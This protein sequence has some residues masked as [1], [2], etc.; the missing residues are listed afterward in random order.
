MTIH[1]LERPTINPPRSCIDGSHM[2]TVDRAEFVSL[3]AVHAC[4]H[5]TSKDQQLV[6]RRERDAHKSLPSN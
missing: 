3:V 5:V 4:C 6:C 2:T 1:S